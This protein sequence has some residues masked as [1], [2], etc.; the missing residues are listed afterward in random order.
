M[1]FYP[2]KYIII[3]GIVADSSNRI[4]GTIARKGISQICIDAF[5]ALGVVAFIYLLSS[6]IMRRSILLNEGEVLR[7][8]RVYGK[9][10]R[11]YYR[12]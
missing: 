9:Y 3:N 1:F 4:L 7:W 12:K 6:F 5:N 2:A 8:C 10:Y 11:K